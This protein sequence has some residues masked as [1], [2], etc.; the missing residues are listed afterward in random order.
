M[1]LTFEYAIVAAFLVYWVL[2]TLC[3]KIDFINLL[4]AGVLNVY[5]NQICLAILW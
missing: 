3:F 1:K 4:E 5:T 2:K